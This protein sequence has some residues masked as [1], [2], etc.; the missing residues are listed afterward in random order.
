M[1]T[2][3]LG[4]KFDTIKKMCEFWHISSSAYK[5]RIN[6][7]AWGIEEALT[8]PVNKTRQSR[9][10]LTKDGRSYTSIRQIAKTTGCSKET[11]SKMLKK[12]LS[13][14][15]IMSQSPKGGP[16]PFVDH[17]GKVFP[18][19]AAA[20][21]EYG[22]STDVILRRLNGGW[23]LKKTLTTPVKKMAHYYIGEKI[24]Q[25]NGQFA[26][27]T[28]MDNNRRGSVKFEDGTEVSDISL[29]EFRRGNVRNP[30]FKSSVGETRMANCGLMMTIIE[31]NSK[32]SLTVQFEDGSTRKGVSYWSFKVGKVS[33]PTFCADPTKIGEF[34]GY[35]VKAISNISN[36]E[37]YYQ[38]EDIRTGEKDIL[39]PHQMMEH[40]KKDINHQQ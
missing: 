9:A 23:S 6:K 7:L 34:M 19:I 18:S 2:D 3:H 22:I 26:E 5:S 35:K 17:N 27:L 11:V 33:H 4:N 16:K 36:G 12:G 20:G 28:R 40:E 15:E 32:K 21:R 1:A 38:T 30:N 14:D 24:K 10:Y 39:T 25:N 8:T 29:A 31:Y 37:V 13:I